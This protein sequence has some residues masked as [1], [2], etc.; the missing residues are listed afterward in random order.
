[1]VRLD[2]DTPTSRMLFRVG[3][4]AARSATLALSRAARLSIGDG[5]DRLR[6]NLTF[7]VTVLP[8]TRDAK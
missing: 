4:S 2:S 5:S 1:V 6:V 3:N 8:R 7:R